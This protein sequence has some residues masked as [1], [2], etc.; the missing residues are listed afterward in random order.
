MLTC[1]FKW[2]YGS[3]YEGHF[4]D[5]NINGKGVY[6]WEI[7]A[8]TS[9]I[10][11]IIKWTDRE[12]SPGRTKDST[13]ASTRM[14]RRMAME[15]SNGRTAGSIKAAGKTESNMEKENSLIIPPRS[16]G[17]ESGMM[18]SELDGLMKLSSSSSKTKNF[19]KI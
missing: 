7:N 17:K 9:A 5:N 10:G 16:G 12:C 15:S 18:A 3:I 11:K 13:K 14:I 2:A 8:I 6:I 4:A 1:K 19:F